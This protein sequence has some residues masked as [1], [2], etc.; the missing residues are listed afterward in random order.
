MN[1]RSS[2]RTLV[3]RAAMRSNRVNVSAWI[4]HQCDTAASRSSVAVGFSMKRPKTESVYMMCAMIRHSVCSAQPHEDRRETN[5]TR[6]PG[7]DIRSQIPFVV[8]Y[9]TNLFVLAGLFCPHAMQN[10]ILVTCQS[11]PQ[12]WRAK[13]LH[14]NSVKTRNSLEAENGFVV[15]AQL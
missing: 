8:F 15:I 6:F 10:N 9:P 1:L 5:T 14:K 3:W 11:E 4:A 13:I 7:A 2:V 12:R